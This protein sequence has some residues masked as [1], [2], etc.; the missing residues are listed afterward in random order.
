[1]K[2]T[3]NNA[4]HET[5][6]KIPPYSYLVVPFN[7]VE[8]KGTQKFK[9]YIAML[10]LE[11]A[12]SEGN[13]DRDK[14]TWIPGRVFREKRILFREQMA[15]P[16]Y[17][18]LFDA[19]ACNEPKGDM[20]PDSS[21][22]VL[23]LQ[24]YGEEEL[25]DNTLTLT[26][27]DN[28]DTKEEIEFTIHNMKNS[29]DAVKIIVNINASVGLIVVPVATNLS[30]DKFQ[31]FIYLIREI[32]QRAI[33]EKDKEEDAWSIQ[34]KILEWMKDFS[35]CYTLTSQEAQHL[36]FVIDETY[37]DSQLQRQLLL[38]ISGSRQIGNADKL[39]VEKF[40]E[41]PG[42]LHICSV[43]EGTTIMTILKD[44][45]ED[46]AHFKRMYSTE[47]TERYI[48]FMS[49]L[50]QR[51]ALIGIVRQLTKLGK[52]ISVKSTE[53]PIIRSPKESILHPIG[54]LLRAA[55]SIK[56]M[57]MHIRLTIVSWW[58]GKP[59][60]K[61]DMLALQRDQIKAVSLIRIEN[62]FSHISEYSL[63]NDFYQ[64]CSNANGITKLYEEIEQ[65]MAMLS[66][67]LTQQS[68]DR[69]EKAEW[70]LSIIL[71]ILTVTSA[72]NDITQLSKGI[73][74]QPWLFIV[75][76]TFAVAIFF[77]IF[78]AIFKNMR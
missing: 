9:D 11:Y 78:R 27:G 48:V 14:L 61:I 69:H 62:Y 40:L 37:R 26:L 6:T 43:M 2:E 8:G 51:Y 7:I 42:Q 32:S 52:L 76:L 50:I 77:Y 63:Y 57:V 18:P 31:R 56:R 73:L 23:S 20:M 64:M 16:H 74:G 65:K 75:G 34:D 12:E 55:A 10:S 3:N 68:D 66:T 58:N 29:F 45:I 19:F 35:G 22:Y 54:T 59:K 30:I 13:P 39:S 17:Q 71:A 72:T 67:Y 15:Y 46:K 21:L 60:S 5:M 4:I 36:S 70:Q 53:T 47:Q 38:R 33:K 1:M 44:G 24:R 28:D 49:V 25:F 41:L